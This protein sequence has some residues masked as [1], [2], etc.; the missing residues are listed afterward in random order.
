MAQVTGWKQSRRRRVFD[1][2]S[3]E[4]PL[5][6]WGFLDR[7]AGSSRPVWQIAG[8]T[9]DPATVRRAPPDDAYPRSDFRPAEENSDKRS[10]WRRQLRILQSRYREYV[11][12]LPPGEDRPRAVGPEVD[13]FLPE[14]AVADDRTLNFLLD[15]DVEK[16]AWRRLVRRGW[17]GLVDARR[18]YHNLLSSQPL[19]FNLFGFLDGHRPA[20]LAV[21]HDVF[22]VDAKEPVE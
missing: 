6:A 3:N 14:E 16:R 9:V 22:E 15:P 11:L 1:E 18:L 8:Q 4:L 12:G 5:Y 17:G 10:P 20:L 21:L 7:T 2:V 13:S 19:C